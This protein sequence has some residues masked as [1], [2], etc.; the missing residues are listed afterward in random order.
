VDILGSLFR[1]KLTRFKIHEKIE[2]LAKLCLE[3]YGN[4][5]IEGAMLFPSRRISEHAR[6]F[7]LHHAPNAS[8]LHIAQLSFPPVSQPRSGSSTPLAAVHLFVL[9]YNLE[10]KNLAKAFWQHSGYGISSRMAEYCL[11]QLESISR[12]D[13]PADPLNCYAR[14]IRRAPYKNRHYAKDVSFG[15]ITPPISPTKESAEAD[16]LTTDQLVYLEERYGR[17]LDISFAGRAKIALR[18]RIAGTLRENVA[19]NEALLLQPGENARSKKGLD[20][21][22]VYLCP[23]GMS[24]I[25]TAHQ[26]LLNSLTPR[27]SVCFGYTHLK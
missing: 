15:K 9:L 19:I 3:R 17:N 21:S 1:V 25:W 8:Q 5:S 12:L 10:Q 7:I 27:K 13:E 18:R 11:L 26:L 2:E 24:A 6:R 22:D 23:T 20:E 4:P 16:D 14:P